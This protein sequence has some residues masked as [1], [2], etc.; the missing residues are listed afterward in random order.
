MNQL[1]RNLLALLVSMLVETGFQ[2][3]EFVILFNS[4]ALKFIACSVSQ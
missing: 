4:S 1:S 2:A 3:E